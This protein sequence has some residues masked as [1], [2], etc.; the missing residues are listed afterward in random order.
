M[1]TLTIGGKDVEIRLR[2]IVCQK[3]L[4]RF[5]KVYQL[6]KYDKKIN[7][8][9]E[10]VKQSYEELRNKLQEYKENNVVDETEYHEKFKKLTIEENNIITRIKNNI[11][12]RY[13][14]WAVWKVMVKKGI[15]PFRK[16]FR[17]YGHLRKQIERGETIKAIGYI[18][19]KL[20]GYKTNVQ[21]MDDDK[22]KKKA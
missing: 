11:P 4:R 6:Q 20:L 14:Y 18:G 9:I 15:W 7:K 12:D 17:S 21:D 16:P 8:E 10:F 3:I 1:D 22:N 2:E 19:E 13:F 5:N